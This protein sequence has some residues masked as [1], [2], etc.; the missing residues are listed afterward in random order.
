MK[1]GTRAEEKIVKKVKEINEKK[2]AKKAVQSEVKAE[3]P[4]KRVS[5]KQKE[6]T[7]QANMKLVIAKKGGDFEEIYDCLSSGA[8]VSKLDPNMTVS[9]IDYDLPLI[10]AI[11]CKGDVSLLKA[12]IAQG[13]DVNKPNFRGITPLMFAVQ[14]IRGSVSLDVVKCLVENG[15][16]VNARRKGEYVDE[17]VL[18]RASELADVEVI[19]YLLENGATKSLQLR[20]IKEYES[21]INPRELYLYNQNEIVN[22]NFRPTSKGMSPALARKIKSYKEKLSVLN[23]AYSSKHVCKRISKKNPEIE[24]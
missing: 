15:A 5:K 8:D 24:L 4:V 7:E 23:E 17:S 14:P 1:K 11:A 13:A 19:K 6:A 3:K 12:V 18:T 2:T 21:S 16:D 9:Y 20:D 10:S 22:P